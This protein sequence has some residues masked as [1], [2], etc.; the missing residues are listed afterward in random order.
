M[1]AIL[2][3][4]SEAFQWNSE[5]S[6]GKIELFMVTPTS[7]VSDNTSDTLAFVDDAVSGNHSLLLSFI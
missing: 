4:N 1:S 5:A 7:F 2:W 3:L 6:L